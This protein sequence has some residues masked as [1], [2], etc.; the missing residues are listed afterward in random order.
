MFP[1]ILHWPFPLVCNKLPVNMT[2]RAYDR[3]GG[4]TFMIGC[5]CQPR[6]PCVH[7]FE[8]TVLTITTRNNKRVMDTNA[9]SI[10]ETF[11][12]KSKSKRL[13]NQHSF[14]VFKCLLYQSIPQCLSRKPKRAESEIPSLP[15]AGLSV[16]LLWKAAWKD[17]RVSPEGA[18]APYCA[19]VPWPNSPGPCSLLLLAC[20][21]Y[22]GRTFNPGQPSWSVFCLF[23]L[24]VSPFLAACDHLF[25]TNSNSYFKPAT[26]WQ[27]SQL[28]SP[29]RWQL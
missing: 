21:V 27:A 29:L 13:C 7:G 3:A 16:A 9:P 18:T 19:A 1:I 23:C 2:R 17:Q 12:C 28:S 15:E 5:V 22:L 20:L 24:S 8:S 4:G 6:R 11:W 10:W 26:V 14:N 25:A